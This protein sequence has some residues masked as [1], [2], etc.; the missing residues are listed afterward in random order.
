MDDL[1]RIAQVRV[2]PAH[3]DDAGPPVRYH[4]EDHTRSSH[5]VVDDTGGWV[6]R[7]EYFAFG[8]TSFGSY[9]RKRFRFQG[10]ERDDETGLDLHDARYTRRGCADG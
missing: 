3:P 2:G 1:R 5:V 8:E 10:Q 6:N 7:E 4:L 9:A